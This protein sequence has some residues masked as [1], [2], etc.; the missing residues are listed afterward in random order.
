M[1]KTGTGVFPDQWDILDKE[2]DE[3]EQ[4]IKGGILS[5]ALCWLFPTTLE[6][7]FKGYK[8]IW[9]SSWISSKYDVMLEKPVI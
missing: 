3:L 6:F 4:K 5:Q 2:V 8:R 1:Y 9:K 7:T